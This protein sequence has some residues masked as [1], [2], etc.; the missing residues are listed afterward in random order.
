MNK[1]QNDTIAAIATALSNSAISIIKVSGDEAIEIVNSIFKGKD[2]SKVKSHTIH[3]GYIID[4]EQVI[5][6]V[7]VSVFKAPKTFTTEDVVEI[8]CHGGIF[9]TNKIL[10]IIL[11]KGARLA[12]PGEFTKRAFL[13]GRIDLTQAEAVIDVIESNTNNSLKMA[14]LGLLGET[15][16]II[17][18]FRDEVLECLLKV[19]VNIDYPEYEDEEQI[20]VDVLLPTLKQ[21]DLEI[22][23][24]LEKSEVSKILKYGIKTAIIG[25]PN[26]G[27]SSLLNA[28]IREDKAIVSNIAGTTRDIVEGDINIGGIVLHLIDTAG[29]HETIDFVEKIG[30]EKS[31]NIIKNADLI[32]LVFDNNSLIN[33]DDEELLRLTANKKRIIVVN[34]KDLERKIDITKFDKPIFVSSFDLDDIHM[35]EQKIKD[36]CNVSDLTNIDSTYI[37]NA[38]QVAKLKIAKKQLNEAIDSLNNGMPIDIASVDINNCWITL[39][40]ILGEVTSEE[41]ID[42]L[43]SRFCLGK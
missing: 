36:I 41:L 37:G 26:V 12:E 38:R 40:E 31:K 32:I 18:K 23:E 20:T 9:V 14:S 33:D 3:Y 34:K 27:K 4:N 19:E 24:V 5:D 7:L 21:L 1:L 10:E 28:L 17:K 30:V 15:K 39:G 29:V 13:G 2:L 35:I 43:F 11:V 16:K 22:D 6:E 25:K 8:N 42:E